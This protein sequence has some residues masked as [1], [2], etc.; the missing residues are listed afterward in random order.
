MRLIA[1]NSASS[2]GFSVRLRFFL[3]L[4]EG[5]R[6]S[7]IRNRPGWLLSNARSTGSIDVIMKCLVCHVEVF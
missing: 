2:A 4:G 3:G 1:Q 7:A 6:C 5:S